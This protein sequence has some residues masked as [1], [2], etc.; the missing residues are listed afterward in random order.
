[1][2]DLD[3]YNE[4][5]VD[6]SLTWQATV[7]VVVATALGGVGSAIAQEDASV[8]A[9]MAGGMLAG[10]VGWLLWSLAS[11]QIGTRLFDGDATFGAMLRV[12]GFAFAPFVIG[13]IPWLG[14]PAAIW[15]LIATIVAFREG[16]DISTVRA[17]GT[18]AIG[19]GLWL[20]STVVLNVL[21]DV[22]LNAR[23]PF[24]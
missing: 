15:V 22:Q 20:G 1:M 17:L 4:A 7:I 11:W 9:A 12:I 23:W 10:V 6:T 16:L 19:W 8:V 18:M 3:F 2:L 13:V 21:L 5:E 24:P 14:F